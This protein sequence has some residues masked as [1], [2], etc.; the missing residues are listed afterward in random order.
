MIVEDQHVNNLMTEGVRASLAQYIIPE[1]DQE[2][3]TGCPKPVERE[4]GIEE[5][6]DGEEGYI[7]AV[8]EQEDRNLFSTK[9]QI[10]D[11]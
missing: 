3:E 6:Q 8:E 10:M 9:S 7:G 5:R 11:E 1:G 4:E 2:A